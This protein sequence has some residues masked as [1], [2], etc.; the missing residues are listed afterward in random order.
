VGPRVDARFLRSELRLELLDGPDAD[1][2]KLRELDD[3]DAG[4]EIHHAASYSNAKMRSQSSFMLTT[5]HPCLANYGPRRSDVPPSV[6]ADAAH[7][8]GWPHDSRAVVAIADRA[9][10]ADCAM[11][12]DASCPID[13]TGA[14]NSIGF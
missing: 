6:D 11:W 7:G 12:S 5:I 8:I 9:T 4:L 10:H 13:A 3:A 1:A 14:D 2:V